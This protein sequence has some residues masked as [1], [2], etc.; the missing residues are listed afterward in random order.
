MEYYINVKTRDPDRVN[1]HARAVSHYAS[2]I[3]YMS[4]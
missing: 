2:V 3:V 1:N 4:S